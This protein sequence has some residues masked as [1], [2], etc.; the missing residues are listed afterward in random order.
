M[1]ND[2][3]RVQYGSFII[4][5]LDKDYIGKH[6]KS[7]RKP[8]IRRAFITNK[9]NIYRQLNALAIND[10]TMFPDMSHQAKYLKEQRY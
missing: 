4:V 9:S 5:G 7:S 10:M 3:M 6:M 1:T 8:L 2:R